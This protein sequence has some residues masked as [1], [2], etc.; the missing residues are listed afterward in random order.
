MRSRRRTPRGST[1]LYVTV[2]MVVL[3]GFVSLAVDLGRVRAAHTELRIAADAGVFAGMQY[4][5][6]DQ[7]Q[8]VA[9]AISTAEANSAHGTAVDLQSSDVEFGRWRYYSKTFEAQDARYSTNAMRV[10]ARRTTARG[11]PIPLGFAK[12]LG[13]N[14]KN[15]EARATAMITGGRATLG[16][17]GIDSLTMVGTAETDSYNSSEG[18]Y[19]AATRYDN[20]DIASNGVI[21]LTGTIDVNGSVHTGPDGDVNAGGNTTVTGDEF[22]FPEPLD[23]P[24]VDASP[25]ATAND[26]TL[27]LL[28]P[29]A[30]E[31]DQYLK[32]T[33]DLTFG[34][35]ASFHIP[36][37]GDAGV[38]PAATVVRYYI[39]NLTLHGTA[40]ITVGHNVELYI[41]GPSVDV[42]GN[43]GPTTT[44]TNPGDFKIF[45]DGPANVRIS[46]Q[47]NQANKFEAVLYAPES[48]ITIGGN[49]DYYGAVI[50]R[51]LDIQ[52]TAGIHY[53]EALGYEQTWPED[54][55]LVE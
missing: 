16:I 54:I 51:T 24:P 27:L 45:I 26:N 38:D 3:V 55:W 2:C 47:G 34:A 20:G 19:N 5:R 37:V 49:T 50:G 22:P 14:S 32:V 10:S 46:G 39:H 31:K 1:L 36:G 35:N 17:V 44:S 12:L 6:S 43:I 18:A 9:D 42:A 33:R 11:N 41:D 40:N 23:Y 48:N 28:P 53:D 15:V 4:M 8:A 52:G 29:P 25:Y 30:K 21:D 7:D 13:F